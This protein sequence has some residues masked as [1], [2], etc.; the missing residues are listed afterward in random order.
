MHRDDG[1]ANDCFCCWEV[2]GVWCRCGLWVNI[3]SMLAGG[4]RFRFLLA[5]TCLTVGL[6][7]ITVSLALKYVNCFDSVLNVEQPCSSLLQITVCF[8]FARKIVCRS[9]C[10]SVR[11]FA[12]SKCFYSGSSCRNKLIFQHNVLLCG[13]SKWSS[14]IVDSDLVTSTSWT[15]SKVMA[16]RYF[17]NFKWRCLWTGSSDQLRV[18][19]Y[20][21]A[22]C[23]QRAN[24]IAYR[25]VW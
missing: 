20:I 12:F 5:R 6:I 16:G 19:I 1:L 13:M 3:M 22:H 7:L 8:W 21:G 17:G 23:Q 14:R 25:L 18:W 24:H 2:H 9:V 10:L 15:K 4:L 11:P